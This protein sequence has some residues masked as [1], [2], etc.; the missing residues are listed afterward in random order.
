[1]SR[2]L[3]LLASILLLAAGCDFLWDPGDCGPPPKVDLDKLDGKTF[4]SKDRCHE[5]YDRKPSGPVE[6]RIDMAEKRLFISYETSDFS[7]NKKRIEE[8][9]RFE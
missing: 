6:L 5:S 9:W 1:M 2:R 8:V 3:L 4:V 7:G